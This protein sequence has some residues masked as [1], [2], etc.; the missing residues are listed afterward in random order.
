MSGH[1]TDDRQSGALDPA[2]KPVPAKPIQQIVAVY[3]TNQNA[4]VARDGLVAAGIPRATIHFVERAD[5]A[6]RANSVDSRRQ[7]LWAIIGSLF[8]PAEDPSMYHLAA[9]PNHALIILQPDAATDMRRAAQILRS[10]RPFYVFPMLGEDGL[11]VQ[12]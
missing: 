5:P 6:S 9:D 7:T 2:A 4:H 11:P 8:S 12:R 10:S 3:E 1:S